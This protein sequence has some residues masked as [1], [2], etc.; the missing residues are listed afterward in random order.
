MKWGIELPFDKDFVT[1]VWFDALINYISGAGYPHDMERFNKYWPADFHVIGKDIIRHHAVYWPIMLKG[2]GIEPPK[3]IFAHGWWVIKGEKMSKSRGNVV[4]PL[5]L[6]ARYGIDPYRYFL[7]REISFGLDGAF[8]E[9]A[10][11][12]R[13]NSDL[14]NDLGNLLNRTLTMTEKYFE[15]KVP[16]AALKSKAAGSMKEAGSALY[17]ELDKAVPN[18]EFA[19]ALEKIWALVGIANKSIEQSKPWVLVKEGKTGELADVIYG[20]LESLRIIAV[21][22]SPFMPETAKRIAEQLGIPKEAID[23]M[24]LADIKVWG[25]LKAGQS[26]NKTAPLFPRIETPKT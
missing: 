24:T 12:A 9:E 17:G 19:I 5:D 16:Q 8:S 25:K 2:A 23:N 21:A 15:G 14:A 20:L 3:S 10:L 1:Y 26:I 18:F 4:D 22:I 6:I 11:V 13:Y 7:L